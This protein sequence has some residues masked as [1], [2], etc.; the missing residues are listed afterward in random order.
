MMSDVHLRVSSSADGASPSDV[1]GA[2]SGGAQ[3]M[4]RGV[5][6]HVAVLAAPLGA[7]AGRH[8]YGHQSC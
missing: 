4:L 3:A 5:T 7:G 8:H 6:A 1:R 2:S